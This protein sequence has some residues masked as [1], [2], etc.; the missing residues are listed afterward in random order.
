MDLLRIELSDVQ[1]VRLADLVAT[2]L[3]QQSQPFNC[4]M[5]PNQIIDALGGTTEV[6]RICDIEP[7][8]VSL[9]RTRGI[10]QARLMYLRLLRPDV[11]AV[12]AETEAKKAACGW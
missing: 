4:G 6:A 11:F 3:A 12:D 5:D 9:W 1:L 10:P 8:A 2:R 7:Q